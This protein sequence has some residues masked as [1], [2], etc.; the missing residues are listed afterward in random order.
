MTSMKSLYLGT[1]AAGALLASVSMAT[2]GGFAV[3]EQSTTYQ[4][5]SFAGAAAGGSGISSMFWNPAT[6]TQAGAGL[7]T[8]SHAALILGNI[9]IHAQPGSTLVGAPFNLNPNSG[10]IAQG[11]LVPAS[12][13]AYRLSPSVVIGASLNSPF[14]LVT[15]PDNLPWAGQI[16]ALTSSIKTY[17]LNVVAGIQLGNGF[18]VGI[19][20]QVQLITGR[21]TAVANAAG[22]ASSILEA[23]DIAVGATAGVHWQAGP[24]TSIGLGYR[25]RLGH[26]LEGD[27]TVTGAPGAGPVEADVNLPDIVTFS[28]RQALNQKLSLAG[29]VE[30]SNW[31]ELQRL[32]VVCQGAG[33]VCPG[34]GVAIQNSSLAW[35]DGW[36]VALGGEYIYSDA[37]TLRAGLAYEKSPIRDASERT[38]RTPD[39]DR[40]WASMGASYQLSPKMTIDLAYTHIFGK[41]SPVDR[42]EGVRVVGEVEANVNIF[43]AALKTKW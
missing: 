26:K 19:G 39:V 13:G 41:T 7:T 43:S 30:W 4:G 40:I 25:S 27:V 35:K 33:G 38:L 28:I 37:M 36:M 12:Y 6:I 3:R 23:D 15:K 17:N 29:S 24:G 1:A 31:S 9:E 2:A 16:Q 42:T 8:E 11:A 34:A 21:L 14:G 32:R 20:P 22:T 10:N 18:S 5:M